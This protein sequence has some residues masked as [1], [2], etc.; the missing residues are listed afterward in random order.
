MMRCRSQMCS[1]FRKSVAVWDKSVSETGLPTQTWIYTASSKC[2]YENIKF[3]KSVM[4]DLPKLYDKIIKMPY[5]SH[6]TIPLIQT[7]IDYL[8][9]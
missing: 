7:D 3:K 2:K 4:R 8:S 6:E 9:M 1:F 5:K